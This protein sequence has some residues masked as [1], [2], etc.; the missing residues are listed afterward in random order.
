LGEELRRRR[1]RRPGGEEEEEVEK[2]KK[3][4]R[5][6]KFSRYNLRMWRLWTAVVPHARVLSCALLVHRGDL[7]DL[8]I[9]PLIQFHVKGEKV[10]MPEYPKVQGGGSLIVAW[11]VKNKHVLVVGGGEV[12]T[13]SYLHQYI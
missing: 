11:Q 6:K 10:K 13:R 7:G 8:G 5:K 9:V 1:R 12:S 4:L 2:E 3:P